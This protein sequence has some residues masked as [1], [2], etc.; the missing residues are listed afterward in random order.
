MSGVYTHA[1]FT[2]SGPHHLRRRAH[3]F[4]HRRSSCLFSSEPRR[5]AQT[6]AS[7]SNSR[8]TH[9]SL[10]L[11]VIVQHSSDLSISLEKRGKKT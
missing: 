2:T 7:S 6:I 3:P 10:L 5:Y 9:A 1:W 8:S 11:G 4:C